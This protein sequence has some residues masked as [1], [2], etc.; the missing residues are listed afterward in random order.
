MALYKLGAMAHDPLSDPEPL[1][2]RVYSYVAYRIGAGPD[3]EDVTSATIERALRYRSSFD[4]RKGKP[5]AWVVGIA[6]TCVDDYLRGRLASS[7]HVE[8]HGASD[9]LERD[10]LLR[11]SVSA[12]VAALDDLDRELISLRYGADLTARQIGALLEMKTNAVEV[13]LHR[14]RERLRGQLEGVGVGAPRP[15]AV[16][17]S[18]PAT[19]PTT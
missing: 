18:G 7:G 13:A 15:P 9:D 11:L 5:E 2:R 1:I 4:P 17:L 10:A 8:D 6:R 14:A 12:A 16:T 3:A 19:E